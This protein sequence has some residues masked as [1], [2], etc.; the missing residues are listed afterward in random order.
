MTGPNITKSKRS[1]EQ[2][3]KRAERERAER[4]DDRRLRPLHM[5]GD[6]GP[7]IAEA[8]YKPRISGNPEVTLAAAF[9]LMKRDYGG[10]T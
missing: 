7:A 10:H 4:A 2:K 1:A 6:I 3:R 9:I 8:D 5:F